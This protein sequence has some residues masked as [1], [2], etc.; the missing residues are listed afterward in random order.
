MK[1]FCV[2]LRSRG[3]QMPITEVPSFNQMGLQFPGGG[4]TLHFFTFSLE[5]EQPSSNSYYHCQAPQPALSTLPPPPRPARRRP[6]PAR[7]RPSSARWIPAVSPPAPPSSRCRACTAGWPGST[8]TSPGPSTWR[9][10][11]PRT[12]SP[13]WTP[14]RPVAV[15]GTCTQQQQGAA[16]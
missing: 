3:R 7:P 15:G 8:P 10:P 11:G 2:K 14:C 16:G 6:P 4:S 5:P 12:S 9:L 13:R 1:Y